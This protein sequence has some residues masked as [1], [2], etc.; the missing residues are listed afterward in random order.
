MTGVEFDFIVKD[1]LAALDLYTKVFGA[2]TVEATSFDKGLNEVVFTIF[3]SR[4][5]MLDENEEYQLF[6]PKEGTPLPMWLNLMVEDIASVAALAEEHGFT[7]VQEV[8][9]MP[10]MG[11]SNAVLYDPFG[12]SWML[13]QMHR[14][15]TFEE[16]VALFEAQGATSPIDN[17]ADNAADNAGNNA[18]DANDASDDEFDEPDD[19]ATRTPFGEEVERDMDC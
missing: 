3:G 7:V 11:V 19:R 12:Y 13:H 1:S 14:I 18:R 4:F 10:E 8:T 16:R 5:H 9:E 15:V 17:P 2:E 6:A